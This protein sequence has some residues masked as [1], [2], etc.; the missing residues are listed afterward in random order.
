MATPASSPSAPVLTP[1][2][3]SSGPA[4][5]SREPEEATIFS[6]F[7]RFHSLSAISG[8]PGELLS[9]EAFGKWSRKRAPE[10]V[11]ERYQTAAQLCQ[12]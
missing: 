9:K 8:T 4:D 2:A 3:N 10:L 11:W 1:G 12:A 7:S 6:S 5:L